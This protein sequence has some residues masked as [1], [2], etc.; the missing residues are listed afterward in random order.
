MPKKKAAKQKSYV[1]E[2]PRVRECSAQERHQSGQR[3]VRELRFDFE[4]ATRAKQWKA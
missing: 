1:K 4:T 3:A 2:R